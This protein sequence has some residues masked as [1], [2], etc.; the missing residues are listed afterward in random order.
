MRT[1]SLSGLPSRTATALLSLLLVLPLGA[2]DEGGPRLERA[3]ARAGELPVDDDDR[4]STLSR[5]GKIKLA[6]TEDILYFRLSDDALREADLE[7]EEDTR[8][9][10]G[11]AGVI[12]SA[13]TGAVSN[14]L[15]TR[16]SFDVQNIRDIRWDD[17]QLVLELEEGPDRL[18]N[19]T[20]DGEDVSTRF[21]EDEIRALA[22]EFE[23][24]K[25][26]R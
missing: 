19:F 13:V 18:E 22:Q 21:E 17:G 2:C 14:A 11:L 15:R 7:M 12:T 26:G 6:L 16:V 20:V 9:E 23:K 8:D 25:R 4:F 1:V 24:V 10:E 5:D 3:G